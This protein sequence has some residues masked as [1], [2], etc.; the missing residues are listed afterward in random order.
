MMHVGI[1]KRQESKKDEATQTALVEM[2]RIVRNFEAGA[3]STKDEVFR[4]LLVYCYRFWYALEE[5]R[6]P[7]NREVR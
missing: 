7:E 1:P 4:T 6:C 3:Y 5:F 2:V